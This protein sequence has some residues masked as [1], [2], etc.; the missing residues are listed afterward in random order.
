MTNEDTC[1]ARLKLEKE[2]LTQID[3]IKAQEEAY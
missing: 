3:T 1:H 2:L